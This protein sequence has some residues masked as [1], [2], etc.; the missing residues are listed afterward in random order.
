M[1]G[2]SRS[3]NSLVWMIYLSSVPVCVAIGSPS[4]GADDELG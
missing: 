2:T 4:K 3:S 1:Q